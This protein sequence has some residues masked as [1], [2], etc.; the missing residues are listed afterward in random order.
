M[1]YQ[2]LGQPKDALQVMLEVQTICARIG[3]KSGIGDAYGVIADLYAEMGFL[4]KA[5]E[6][7]DRYLVVLASEDWLWRLMDDTAWM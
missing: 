2:M 6:Y 7:Y 4:D 5:G 1:S 3:D